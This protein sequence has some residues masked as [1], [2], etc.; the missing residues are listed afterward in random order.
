MRI[1]LNRDIGFAAGWSF[2]AAVT[3][4]LAAITEG[5]FSLSLGDYRV[6]VTTDTILNSASLWFFWLGLENVY[7]WRTG[8]DVND[9]PLARDIIG[10]WRQC[11]SEIYNKI[12]PYYKTELGESKI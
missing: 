2:N 7:A 4:S 1:G 5:R 11:A 9:L 3:Y 10:N 8:K 12:K 6:S